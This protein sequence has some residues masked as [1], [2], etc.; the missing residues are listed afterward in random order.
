MPAAGKHVLFDLD[1]TLI[2]SAP[3]LA[4]ALN[5][6]LINHGKQTLPFAQIRPSVSLGGT[7]MIRLGFNITA[8]A[9]GFE[10]LRGEFLEIYSNNIARH[11]RLFPGMEEVLAELEN[12]G[13][14]WGIVTNKPGWLTAPL[15]EEMGL[16]DR[17]DCIVSG[18]TLEMRKP[19]PAPI[20]HACE[21]LNCSPEE[22]IYIGDTMGDIAAGTG[23]GMK[24]LIAA[25][26]YISE[27]AT[28]ETWGADGI[29]HQ[30][31]QIL[32]WLSTHG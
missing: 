5:Q 32:D 1:G 24:T 29:I 13:S 10:A 19:H 7:G 15:M 30:P 14:L 26:G 17:A 28:P 21:L 20:L 11:S 18:D 12:N 6:T 25:Y 2:D 22:A 23:A 27:H 4:N 16:G 31:L 8:D 9:P 3:D